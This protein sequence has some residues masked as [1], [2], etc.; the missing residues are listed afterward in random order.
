MNSN[1]SRR[2]YDREFKNN[3]I[4]PG[5]IF[6][7]GSVGAVTAAIKYIRKKHTRT[8]GEGIEPKRIVSTCRQKAF[9]AIRSVLRRMMPR[10]HHAQPISHELNPIAR[11]PKLP[12]NDLPSK[13]FDRF[14]CFHRITMRIA[15]AA[16]Q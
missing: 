1:S 7:F 8:R 13:L 12:K 9:L 15:Q 5:K 4:A 10:P 11:S 2:R 3:A 6:A 14:R 16:E